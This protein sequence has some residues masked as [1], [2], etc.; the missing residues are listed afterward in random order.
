MR[1]T[2]ETL[3]TRTLGSPWA[4]LAKRLCNMNDCR[5]SVWAVG[6]T[7]HACW[8]RVEN[9]CSADTPPRPE[10]FSLV[11]ASTLQRALLERYRAHAFP[12]IGVVLY[13]HISHIGK[14][15]I[16][17]WHT[18]NLH[19]VLG[20]EN[21]TLDQS[22][23]RSWICYCCHWL[24]TCLTCFRGRICDSQITEMNLSSW[25]TST[26]YQNN[27]PQSCSALFHHW[28]NA[29]TR[30][31]TRQELG[32]TR[33]KYHPSSSVNPYHCENLS[34]VSNFLSVRFPAYSFTVQANNCGFFPTTS[35]VYLRNPPA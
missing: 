35:E 2:M 31:C 4:S 30:D 18:S 5:S 17:D 7:R 9:R 26:L 20:I 3:Y 16:C 15:V 11:V 13:R 25:F 19:S 34:L 28:H 21:L 8:N 27:I 33:P 24:H 22:Y 14:H 23:T 32:H 12:C 29:V 1:M 6:V 10:R